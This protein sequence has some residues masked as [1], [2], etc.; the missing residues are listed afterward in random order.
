MTPHATLSTF[1][2][3]TKLILMICPHDTAQNPERWYFLTQYLSQQLG[4]HVEFEQSLQFS[5]FHERMAD[6]DLVYANPQDSLELRHQHH[7][8]P[9]VRP[10]NLYDEVVFVASESVNQPTLAMLAGQRIATV[11]N[12]L[13]TKVALQLLHQQ[14][15]HPGE[16]INKDSWLAVVNSLIKGETDFAFVYQDTYNSLSATSREMLQPFYR[17]TQQV[18][19]HNLQLNPRQSQHKSQLEQLLLLMN[20]TP[21]GVEVLE[22]L[23]ISQW[24]SVTET[25]LAV[26]KNLIE[27][28]T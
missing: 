20:S 7:F 8:I 25:E 13:L 5:E 12:M 24:L 28:Y 22:R 3:M 11:T 9:L 19:F 26:I 18:A 21:K 14:A 1:Y 2:L 15:I 16:L 27:Q 17:S 6:A 4:M 10:A 23:S